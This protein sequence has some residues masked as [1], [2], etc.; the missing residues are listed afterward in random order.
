MAAL[1]GLGEP[2]LTHFLDDSIKLKSG[3]IVMLG[4]RDID[5]PEAE[6]LKEHHIRYYKWDYI[7][8]HGLQNCLNESIDYLSH[9]PAVHVSFDIDSMDPKLM[10]ASPLPFRKVSMKTTSS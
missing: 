10:P 4:L 2:S 7:M 9:C 6:I 8:E 1:L 3:N 5:P